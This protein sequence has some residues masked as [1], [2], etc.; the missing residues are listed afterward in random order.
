MSG[1]TNPIE[2][3]QIPDII[4]LETEH[5]AHQQELEKLEKEA[6]QLSEA[7]GAN[8]A[9]VHYERAA[10]RRLITDWYANL[11][12]TPELYGLSFYLDFP[13]DEK[14]LERPEYI[15]PR[16]QQLH[17]RGKALVSLSSLLNQGPQPVMTFKH[18]EKNLH[19][20]NSFH[21][22]DATIG[23]TASEEP[24]SIDYRRTVDPLTGTVS[25]E[26]QD[27][28]LRLGPNMRFHSEF[29]GFE[30][31]DSDD[32]WFA[33]SAPIKERETE[34]FTL[35]NRYWVNPRYRT[36]AVSDPARTLTFGQRELV[37]FSIASS[38]HDIYVGRAAIMA[39]L[40]ESGA[41]IRSQPYD[42]DTFR[43]ITEAA[44]NAIAEPIE[45]S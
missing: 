17:H 26:P 45:V 37:S 16:I 8:V 27:V 4:T 39:I 38:E 15:V 31:D 42:I 1:A 14:M 9:N 29:E 40:I 28:R 36:G 3:S 2:E 24:V 5:Q 43:A 41:N 32:V 12:N 30:D 19:T 13:L 18:E 44:S 23:L 21:S 35:L 7:Q 11:A 22:F 33:G 25:L 10:D 6:S 20:G 34:E